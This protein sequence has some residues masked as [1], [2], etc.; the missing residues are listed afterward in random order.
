MPTLIYRE[1]RPKHLSRYVDF[2]WYFEGATSYY[3][4]E[5][6][7]RGEWY[8]FAMSIPHFEVPLNLPHAAT[9]AGR[10]G[11]HVSGLLATRAETLPVSGIISSRGA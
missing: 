1:H 2:L 10:I 4:C 3:R 7:P 5:R 9:V 11:H 8:T 6:R